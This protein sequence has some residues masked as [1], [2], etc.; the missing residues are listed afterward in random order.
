LVESEAILLRRFATGADAEA[1]AE[2]VRRY[3]QMVYSASW[4]VLKD[5]T[6]ATDV[7]QETFFELTRHAGR[8]SG[9][10]AGWLH[11]VATQK[12]I[13]VIRRTAH[14]RKRER[15]Y[16]R[17]RP[18]EVQSWQDMSEHVDL[19]LDSLP[20][21]MRTILLDHFVSGK[22]TGQIAAERG[23]SQAT[24]SRR[25]NAG[26]E[27]LRGVLRRKGLLVT[28]AA[29]GTML[30]ENTAQA[31]S[32]TVM[33]GLGR[34]AMV[35]TTGAA[36]TAT[37]AVVAKV[38]LGIAA[39][40][41]TIS[42]TGY[43]HQRR[44]APAVPVATVSVGGGV[45][46]AVDDNSGVVAG[47]AVEQV[48]T[49][50]ITAAGREPDAE[51]PVDAVP[52]EIETPV[53]AAVEEV[54]VEAPKVPAPARTLSF[55]E[56]YSLGVVYVRDADA[57]SLEGAGAFG[58]R[59]WGIEREPYACARGDVHVP[60]G[61]RITLSV[62]GTD[63]TDE[64]YL[65]ALEW[66]GPDDLWG[67][68][69][70]AVR[71]I[72]IAEHLIAPIARL[73]GLRE[74]TFNNVHIGPQ[75]LALIAELPNLE[76]LGTP[77][78][79]ADS[80]MAPIAR[81]PALKRLAIR[82]GGLTDEGLRRLG[83]MTSL[84]SLDL[85]TDPGMTDVGLEALAGL[86][87][88][89]S[90][91]LRGNGRFT[92]IGLGHLAGL[93]ALE[94]LSLEISDV[95]D[96]GLRVLA[97]SGSLEHLRL[98]WRGN[99]TD[100][101][102]AC[103]AGMAQLKTL[104][105]R[106]A[107]LTDEALVHLSSMPGL[108]ELRLSNSFSDAGIACLAGMDSLKRLSIGCSGR[109][110]LADGALAIVSGMGGLEELRISGAEC[111]AA[112]IA[113]L[114]RLEN[115]EVLSINTPGLD[116]DALGSLAA[117]PKLR[118]LSCGSRGQLAISGLRALNALKG[119]E[120]LSVADVRQDD[121]GLDLSGLVNLRYLSLR[122]WSET[123]RVRSAMVTKQDGLRDGDLACLCGLTGL[124]ELDLGGSG[125]GDE[126]LAH[127]ACLTKL[128]RLH[129]GGGNALTDA[130]LDHLAGLHRLEHLDIG[131]S[132]I[133][134]EGLECLYPLKTLQILH[135]RS[136]VSIGSRAVVRLGTELPHLQSLNVAR[137]NPTR[138]PIPSMPRITRSIRWTWGSPMRPPSRGRRRR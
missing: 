122:M 80:G 104:D 24:V 26:L 100:D 66:L 101:G 27:Q 54:V 84:E 9:S 42:V 117:L 56:A 41:G 8:I 103:L 30:L 118:E 63:V 135:I 85:D 19:A 90:L 28:T 23:F 128:K 127:L 57:V 18:V 138:W 121:G 105:V 114:T 86:E 79:I 108:E 35:G 39:V 96:E 83:E 22:T 15:V 36:T 74:L 21:A 92:E 120:K 68:E 49:A 132:R 16:A 109:S 7:T 102:I 61:K 46:R 110:G 65:A 44:S 129:V 97:G 107:R 37:K 94:E 25:V 33:G 123:K 76:V 32:A 75:S 31:V 51:T 125:I 5:E 64:R 133:T 87:S 29:L 124:E 11:R 12:S 40:V 48:G 115:L 91:R 89:R 69:F 73:S 82:A 55:A 20:E 99:V 81:A 137:P 77:M 6:D 3:V 58:L 71:P 106:L 111:T 116:D 34:M 59:G 119:L 131:V 53:V 14:R 60:A 72:F 13:D 2:L 98:G 126:G 17:G 50:I 45:V 70:H 112:G 134:T 38:A 62:R 130:G 4:R 136:V 1:F 88:L 113:M 93:P 52:V 78:G 67:L 47:E 43:I 95:E 10:L